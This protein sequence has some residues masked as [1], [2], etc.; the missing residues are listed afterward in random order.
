MFMGK[1]SVEWLELYT[2]MKTTTGRQVDACVWGRKIVEHFMQAAIE[3][4][5]TRNQLIH[6]TEEKE[7]ESPRRR[8]A[9]VKEVREL[10]T[11]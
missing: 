9:L 10:Q 1:M 8:A 6:K 4:W 11:L 7:Q 5:E 2:Q 3:A